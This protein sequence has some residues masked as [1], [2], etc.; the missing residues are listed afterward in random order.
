MRTM[1]SNAQGALLRAVR[2]FLEAE[3]DGDFPAMVIE[4]AA[5]EDWASA[6]FA[7][8]RHRFELAFRGGEMD[9]IDRLIAGLG[10][11]ELVIPGH[12]VADVALIEHEMREDGP[13]SLHRLVFEALTVVD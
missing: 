2:Q 4:A 8:Q 5:S 13:A 12:I 11:A 3:E 7:G 9:R 1:I 6:T 10:Q